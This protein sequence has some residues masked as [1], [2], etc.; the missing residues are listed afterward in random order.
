[1]AKIAFWITA[2]PDLRDKALA[3]IVLAGRLKANRGQDIQVYFFGPGVQLAGQ[4]DEQIEQALKALTDG[5]VPMAACPFN[6][7]Q[8]GVTE[9]VGA[10]GITMEPAG[11]ALIRLV[12][13]G[14][15]IVGV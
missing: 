11:E 7:D 1:M 5:S 9:R 8:Y 12:E 2:G 4:A 10:K 14:Y 13:Q 15:Q 3:N 6:A